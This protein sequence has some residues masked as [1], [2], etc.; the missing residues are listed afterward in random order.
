MKEVHEKYSEDMISQY[1]DSLQERGLFDNPS[2]EQVAK[3]M[4]AQSSKQDYILSDGR[5]RILGNVDN[6]Y[7]IFYVGTG[8][9]P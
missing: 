2:R 8:K 3:I 4:D 5:R 1:E 9:T 7:F 6:K